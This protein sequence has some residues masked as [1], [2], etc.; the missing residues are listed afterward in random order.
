M[1]TEVRRVLVW[2]GVVRVT[3][4]AMVLSLLVLLPTGW[5]L[6]TGVIACD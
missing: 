5:L 6:T 4:W 1:A 3:H 2:P